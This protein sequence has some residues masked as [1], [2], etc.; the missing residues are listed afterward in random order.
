MMKLVKLFPA[1]V[2]LDITVSPVKGRYE[3]KTLL[4]ACDTACYRK[5]LSQHSYDDAAAFQ[6]RVVTNIESYDIRLLINNIVTLCV[7]TIAI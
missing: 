6:W 4:M 2:T 1:N 5:V 7:L 3:N